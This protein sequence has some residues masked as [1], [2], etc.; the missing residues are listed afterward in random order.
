MRGL[1]PA[2]RL[3]DPGGRE[4]RTSGELQEAVART[5]ADNSDAGMRTTH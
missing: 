1:G 2:G 4:M 3:K 5:C